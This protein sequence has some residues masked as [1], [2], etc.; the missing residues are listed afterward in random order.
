VIANRVDF[1]L[2]LCTYVWVAAG[3]ALVAAI[4]GEANTGRLLSLDLSSLK[5]DSQLPGRVCY[6][7]T[8]LTCELDTFRGKKTGISVQG[9]RV[10]AS[11]GDGSSDIFG[12]SRAKIHPQGLRKGWPPAP[13]FMRQI[14]TTAGR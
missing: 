9:L 13:H 2:C 14:A 6:Y 4:T 8:V 10:Q 5:D 12:G 1:K 11:L 3:Q 7:S